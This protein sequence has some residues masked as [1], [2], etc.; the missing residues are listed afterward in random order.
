MLKWFVD[1]KIRFE[2]NQ[3][4]KDARAVINQAQHMFG[5]E[6]LKIIAEI[7]KVELIKAHNQF[8]Q[9]EVDLK[10]ALVDCK[11][12][13][14]EAVKNNDQKFLSAITLVII[15]IRSQLV[16]AAAAPARFSINEFIKCP[17]AKKIGNLSSQS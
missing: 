4:N 14:K 12:F 8:G 2:A 7:L 3:L 5:D 16:G 10:R 15:F 6:A 11:R 1:F 9:T 17:F 13:H